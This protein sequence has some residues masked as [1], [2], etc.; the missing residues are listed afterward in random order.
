MN[1]EAESE[2]PGIEERVAD[3]HSARRSE[4]PPTH[5]ADAVDDLGARDRKHRVPAG[6]KRFPGEPQSALTHLVTAGELRPDPRR[7]SVFAHVI[8]LGKSPAEGH[9]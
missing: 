4:V 5:I 7:D 3:E 2:Q 9:R 8:P 6:K 1:S